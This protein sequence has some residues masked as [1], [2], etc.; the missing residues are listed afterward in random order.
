MA[1]VRTA[2]TAANPMRPYG[3]PPPPRATTGAVATLRK[4]SRLA[5]GRSFVVAEVVDDPTRGVVVDESVV[6]LGALVVGEEADDDGGVVGGAVALGVVSTLTVVGDGRGR[7]VVGGVVAGGRVVVVGSGPQT[8]RKETK[9]DGGDPVPHAQAS[10]SP[11]CTWVSPAPAC[12]YVYCVAP[13]GA[14]K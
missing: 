11:S 8:S 3:D 14:R 1:A 5:A 4:A 12:E 7:E 13:A 9:G 2:S 6:T 10:T